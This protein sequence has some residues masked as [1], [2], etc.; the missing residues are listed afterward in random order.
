MLEFK[1]DL[2]WTYTEACWNPTLITV[3]SIQEEGH[4]GRCL[5]EKMEASWLAS[6]QETVEVFDVALSQ[7][8]QNAT[9]PRQVGPRRMP[10]HRKL[11]KTR[12]VRT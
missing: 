2:C 10:T 5:P 11:G 8:H 7:N 4:R 12:R 3:L 6:Q 1:G 9:V